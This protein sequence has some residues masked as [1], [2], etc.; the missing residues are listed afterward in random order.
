MK[1][2]HAK[3]KTEKK[4][5]LIIIAHCSEDTYETKAVSSDH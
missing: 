5:K 4:I 1:N 2:L 3:E